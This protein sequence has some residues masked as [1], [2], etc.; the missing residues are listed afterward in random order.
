M[1]SL[2][3]PI[4]IGYALLVFAYDQL[5]AKYYKKL[6]VVIFAFVIAVV[7]L[8]VLIQVLGYSFFSLSYLIVLLV[9]Q[10][11]H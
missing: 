2:F 3:L 1:Y 8:L 4:N 6:L 7:I 9:G 11:V 5:P 10:V